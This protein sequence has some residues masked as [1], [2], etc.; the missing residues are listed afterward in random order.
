MFDIIENKCFAYCFLLIKTHKLN[1]TEPSIQGKQTGK[2]RQ[3][4]LPH[5]VIYEDHPE[6]QTHPG[7]L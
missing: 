6:N 1:E 4:I 5:C 3:Y 7:L 2:I